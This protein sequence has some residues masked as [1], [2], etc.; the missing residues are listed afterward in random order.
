LRI[1]GV[2][3]ETDERNRVRRLL[4]GSESTA[5]KMLAFLGVNNLAQPPQPFYG[6]A[7]PPGNGSR[8]S[9]IFTVSSYSLA[10]RFE[11]NRNAANDEFKKFASKIV[12]Y[13]NAL[14]TAN[15]RIA[16]R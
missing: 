1:R 2:F 12:L 7:N 11:L 16:T 13:R 14:L 8:H 3:A 10:A 6:L 9:P 15:P 4:L 5:S